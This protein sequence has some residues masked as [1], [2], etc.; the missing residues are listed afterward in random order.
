M[1]LH[2]NQNIMKSRQLSAGQMVVHYLLM[3]CKNTEQNMNQIS[4]DE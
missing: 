4:Q 1:Y 2:Q 3:Y